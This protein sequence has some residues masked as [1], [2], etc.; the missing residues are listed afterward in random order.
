MVD[1]DL[2]KLSVNEL[3]ELKKKID[4]E[5]KTRDNY[6]KDYVDCSDG[7]YKYFRES[8]F[9]TFERHGIDASYSKEP[10]RE[11]VNWEKISSIAWRLRSDALFGLCDAAFCNYKR[12]PD[13]TMT[14]V[15]NGTVLGE[16]I[17]PELY[18]AMYRELV[19]VF[20]KYSEKGG[21]SDV[22]R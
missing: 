3:I 9:A 14:F 1:V 2:S 15:R 12:K 18:K 16:G 6:T 4:A 20:V 19:D 5:Q 22:V 10:T 8:V 17:D 21:S 11:K 13:G 7:A